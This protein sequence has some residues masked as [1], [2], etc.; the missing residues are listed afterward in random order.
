MNEIQYFIFFYDLDKSD[1]NEFRIRR[2]KSVQ[3]ENSSEY[4]F[5]VEVYKN[6]ISS[7]FFFL[8]I[9]RNV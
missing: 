8:R 3:S 2:I 4:K 5:I 7:G 1:Q 9:I 6:C